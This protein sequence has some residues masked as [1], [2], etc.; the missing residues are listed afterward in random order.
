MNTIALDVRPSVFQATHFPS[1]LRQEGATPGTFVSISED[2]FL[3]DKP[4]FAE[5]RTSFRA[6]T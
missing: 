6:I 1:F 2:E 4:P 5:V 3:A